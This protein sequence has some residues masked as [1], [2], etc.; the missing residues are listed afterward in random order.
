MEEPAKH[1]VQGCVVD[2]V[3]ILLFELGVSAL[4]SDKVPD[5]HECNYAQGG[6]RAPVDERIS[7]KEVLDDGV[8]PATH[9][10]TNMKKRPFPELGSEIILLVRVWDKSI[11]GGHH[12]N[13]QMN[14]ILQE[15]RLIGSSIGG[16]YYNML[17]ISKDNTHLP[18]TLIIPV[19]LNVPVSV[20]I[21]GVVGLV[22]CNFNLLETPLR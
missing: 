6:S 5:N 18:L 14:E 21:F 12:G 22:T 10:K 17:A 20:N 7:E 19:G 11:V 13:I 8:I 9:T 16:G 4:P 15:W 3:D 2:L 1:R